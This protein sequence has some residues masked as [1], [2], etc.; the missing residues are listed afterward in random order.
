M[1]K[2]IADRIQAC[3]RRMLR[4]MAGITLVDRVASE[5]V[6]RR[7]GV[8]PVLLAIREG[9]LRWFGQV[10]RREGEGGNRVGGGRG[11]SQLR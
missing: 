2:K 1:T 6:A 5:E 3:D 4:Y 11:I 8:K 10:K 9:R 7:C